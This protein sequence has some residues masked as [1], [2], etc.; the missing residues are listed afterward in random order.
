MGVSQVVLAG[1]LGV[2]E[3]TVSRWERGT[4]SVPEPVALLIVRLSKEAKSK[5]K[6]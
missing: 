3:M 5:G 4:V 2:H 6:R 1:R